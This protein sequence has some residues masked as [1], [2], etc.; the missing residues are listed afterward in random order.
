MTQLTIKEKDFVALI[1][2]EIKDGLYVWTVNDGASH[3]PVVRIELDKHQLMG[4]LDGKSTGAAKL[5]NTGKYV[6][7]NLVTESRKVTYP[8][9]AFDDRAM[10]G[11]WL[12]EHKKEEGWFVDPNVN[13]HHSVESYGHQTFVNYRVFK[14]V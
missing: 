11:R 2:V 4:I 13:F 7:K 14:F 10:I 5:Y 9:N 12:L 1:N 8:G 6:G 3:Q